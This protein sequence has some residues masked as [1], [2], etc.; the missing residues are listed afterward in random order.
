MKFSLEWLKEHLETDA[1]AQDIADKLTAIGLE[2]EGLNNPAEALAPFRV[3][4][5]LTAEKHPQADKLQILTVD[6]GEGPMQVVC[7]A[8]NARAGMLGVFGPPGAYIPGSGITLKVAAIRGV[9]SRGMMCSSRELELGDDHGGIIELPADAPVGAAFTDYSGLNDPVFDVNVTPNR[10]DAMGVRGIARDLAAAG[11]GTLKPLA[12]PQIEGSFPCPV[13]IRIEDPDGCPAFFGRAIRGVTNRASPDWMQRRLKSAG[14]RPISALVDITNY[15]MLDHGRPAHA[16]D[17]ARL[18]GGLTARA[19]KA[20]E[21]VLALNEKEYALE[22]FM[23]VIADDKQV[24]DIGGI[25]GGEDS[26]VSAATADVMLEVAYFTPERIAR[27]G[28][29]LGLTSD[30]RSRFERGV[31]PAFLDDGL[32]ILTGLILHICGGE[33]SAAIRAGDPPVERRTIT[34]DFGRTRALG[35]IDVPESE[36]RS[37]LDRLGFEVRGKDV[38]VP[39]WRRDVEGAADLVEEIARIVGYD[40]VP[41]TPLDRSPGVAKPTATRSQLLERRVRRT[42]AARGLDEAVTWSFISE[43]EAGAFGGG[44]WKL[45]NPISEDMKVMRPSLLPG[46]IAAARRNLDRGAPSVRLFEIG[47]RYLADGEHATLGLLLAGE[48][49]PRGWQAGKAQAFDPFDAKAEVLALLDAAGAPIG[50]LQTFPDA[51]P[52]WHPGRSAKV[53]LGPKTLLAAFGELHPSLAKTLDA[54]A[55][56]VAAEIYLSAIPVGRGGGHARP[57]YAPP[58]LQAVTRD[59]AFVVPPDLTADAL[60]RAIRGAD[61]AAI[62]S[63]RLFDRFESADGLSLAFEV[64]LQPADKS[65]TDDQIGEIAQRIVAAAEKLGARL[66]S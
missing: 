23:T 1:S 45:A 20:G 16:Y 59:F 48:R 34:F 58:A 37:I 4:K 25:M 26:G 3:A 18:S 35:G 29:A 51:G 64:T 7:G 49:Q 2:V 56:A 13:P 11:I 17:I 55:G 62:T 60:L 50:N 41:S 14:Q 19:A 10:P 47:R 53:G 63:V 15:V 12:V 61:K 44:E 22:P 24:H 33:P 27:T 32:E 42:A 43:A 39:T 66:R 5:V 52:T 31:D 40:Q 6:A 36:Q 46:L 21:R 9:E 28:Q 38:T 65:F 57:A 30:A 8:P 54:P